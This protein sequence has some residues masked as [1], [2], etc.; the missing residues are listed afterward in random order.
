MTSSVTIAYPERHVWFDLPPDSEGDQSV[1]FNSTSE[2]LIESFS[3]V[4]S[5][6]SE[7]ESD[8]GASD[9]GESITSEGAA[10][11]SQPEDTQPSPKAQSPY[12]RPRRHEPGATPWKNK[13]SEGGNGNE[14]SKSKSKKKKSRN[15]RRVHSYH[16][17]DFDLTGRNDDVSPMEATLRRVRSLLKW[18]PSKK[19]KYKAKRKEYIQRIYKAK[20]NRES[21]KARRKAR[22]Q[23]REDN[24]TLQQAMKRED[25]PKFE[26]AIRVELVQQGM[27]GEGIF[28]ISKAVNYEDLP[29]DAHLIGSMFVLA[30]KRNPTTGK[31][32]KYK[33]HLVG[34][35]NQQDETSYD[36]IKSSTARGSS[37]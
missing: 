32:E 12:V 18:E 28:N 6:D 7:G 15:V 16:D 5:T 37:V 19:D 27:D 22:K 24:P 9:S 4:E 2:L 25:W 29:S 35:G 36:N 1:E 13:S 17:F 11:P 8:G 20:W 14:A 21:G 30:V 34:F 10:V 26:E 33:A 23:H 3:P 31:T